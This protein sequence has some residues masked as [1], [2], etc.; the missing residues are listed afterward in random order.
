M[1]AAPERVLVT[2][3]TG[4]VGS[5]L[6]RLLA[7]EGR[8][9]HALARAGSDRGPL[10]DLPLTWHAGDLEDAP[11]IERAVAA[12]GAGA[13]VVHSAAVISYRTAD[14]ALQ[15]RVN[16]GGTRAVLDA[17]RR[18]G[19]GRVVHV[20]SVVAVGTAPDARGA[21]DE[22]ADWNGASMRC[23]YADTKRAAEELALGA[24]DELDVVAVLPGAIFGPSPVP[25][26]T[27]RFLQRIAAGA[28]GPAAPPGSLSVVGVDDAARGI[29]AALDRGRRGR[30]Y[31]LTD[32]NLTHRELFERAAAELGSS[33]PRLTLP[34]PL[35]SLV[36][37]GCALVDR[38][39][40]LELATPQALRLLGLHFRYDSGRA[41]RELGWSPRPFAE[42]LRETVAW[43]RGRGLA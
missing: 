37:G 3:A 38:L 27:T 36:V 32:E 26:N 42:I 14:R 6:A 41:R 13:A 33:A 34:R 7:E 21:L 20:S 10:E 25:S 5:T 39:R 12:A 2:G 8:E 29:R 18:A 28:L 31:L 24:A 16:V 15:E 4:F 35:W 22:D 23:A 40:P 9:V 1:S 11:S 43:M 17:C 30:R 19:A